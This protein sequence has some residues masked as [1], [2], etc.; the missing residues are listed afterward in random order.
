MPSLG[1]DMEEGTL[2]EWRVKAG[3]S[4]KRGDVVALVETAKG[5]IDVEIFRDASIQRLLVEQGARVPVGTPLAELSDAGEAGDSTIRPPVESKPL[6]PATPP[7]IEPVEIPAASAAPAHPRHRASPA[8][9]ARAGELGI[10]IEDVRGSGPG[11]VVTLEDVVLAAGKAAKPVAA[12]AGAPH[13]PDMRAVIARAMTRSKREIPHYYLT[14]TCSF[15]GARAW[16]AE[17]NASVPI[18]HR[19]LP[20][21]LLLKAVALAARDQPDFNGS[22]KDGVFEAAPAVHVGMAIAMRGGRLV[23][24][25]I[26]D[27]DKKPLQSVMDELRDLTTRVRSGRMRATELSMS[28]ITLTSLGDDGIDAV[29]PAIYPPQVAIVGVGSILERPWIVAG[30]VKPAHVVT[31]SLAADHRVTDGRAGARFIGQIARLLQTPEQL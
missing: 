27:A 29:I 31:L 3:D 6:A 13:E 9:R 22:F 24:P 2:V 5:V 10:R 20:S 14:T 8:A 19:I 18:E 4:V 21:A 26:I 15:E 16:L 23:A 1:P 12:A 17:H 7:V 25:A 28:T 11:G 30:V